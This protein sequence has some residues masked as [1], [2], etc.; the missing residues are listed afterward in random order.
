MP[1]IMD[2]LFAKYLVTGCVRPVPPGARIPTNVYALGLVDKNSLTE[3]FRCIHDCRPKNDVIDDWPERKMYGLAALGY[4]Y[5]VRCWCFHFD[6]TMA[7]YSAS[8]MGCGGGLRRTGAL[9][10][11]GSPEYVVGCVPE[12]YG[13]LGEESR[14]K[15]GCDKDRMG[16]FWRHYWVF[17]SPAFGMKVSSNCLSMLTAPFARRYRKEG[18]RL[19]LWVDDIKTIV[20]NPH[21]RKKG[22]EAAM[23]AGFEEE[24]ECGGLQSCSLCQSSYMRALDL[25]ARMKQDFQDLGW[26]TNDKDADP[27]HTG[28]FTGIHYDSVRCVFHMA[29]S[30]VESLV[31]LIRSLLAGGKCTRRELSQL[32]GRLGWYACCLCYVPILTRDMN[33]F[34]GSPLTDGEWDLLLLISE[35]VLLEL[36]F[37]RVHLPALATRARPMWQFSTA[38]LYELWL[39]GHPM[40]GG[41]LALDASVHGF[42]AHFRVLPDDEPE[43]FVSTPPR[44]WDWSEQV[45]REG[46]AYAVAS[47]ACAHRCEGRVLLVV[48][49]CDPV[50]HS[51]AKGAKGSDVLHKA[52]RHAALEALKHDAALAVLWAPGQRMVDWGIDGL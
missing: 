13:L 30:K 17:Q 26:E 51:A 28:L 27:S 12:P 50:V 41:C 23:L 16:F 44:G 6:I 32:R 36:H 43:E 45:Y 9:R 19:V 18:T 21:P 39:Q 15:G 47:A 22:L 42:G 49:D 24:E 8:L 38:Q 40:I 35:S 4:L 29:Q 7:Y 3:P 1:E 33:K 48:S 20:L 34:I 25:Q 52:V 2:N 37:W 31:E 14:C 46:A 5:G 11:D 10:H